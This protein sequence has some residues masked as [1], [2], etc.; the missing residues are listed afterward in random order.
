MGR[1]EVRKARKGERAGLSLLGCADY[2]RSSTTPMQLETREPGLQVVRRA[3][4]VRAQIRR[5]RNRNCLRDQLWKPNRPYFQIFVGTYPSSV[6]IR[7]NATVSPQVIGCQLPS[8]TN[9]E[10][11][12]SA[13]LHVSLFAGPLARVSFS[14][15]ASNQFTCF[16]V[17][18]ASSFL[19]PQGRLVDHRVGVGLGNMQEQK[20][21]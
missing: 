16:E 12:H 3:N 20:T 21:G 8:H 1:V 6:A 9:I 10:A 13:Q 19:R 18:C 4:A 7:S 2:R 14:V 15:K 5:S 11:S 17:F